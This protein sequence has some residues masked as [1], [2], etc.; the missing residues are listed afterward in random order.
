VFEPAA[1][2]DNPPTPA[3]LL[4]G[5]TPLAAPPTQADAFD[6]NAKA[7]GDW[8]AKERADGVASGLIDPQTGWP[9]KAGLEDAAHQLADSMLMG[10]TAPGMKGVLPMDFASHGEG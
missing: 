5:A 9:T 7:Y 4:N 6:A 2:T 3:S 1:G 8:V 10:T